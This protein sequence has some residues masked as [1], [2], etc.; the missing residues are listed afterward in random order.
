MTRRPGWH[1]E[2]ASSGPVWSL[3]ARKLGTTSGN[4]LRTSSLAI[5]IAGRRIGQPE[6]TRREIAFVTLPPCGRVRWCFG[7]VRSVKPARSAGSARGRALRVDRPF[8]VDAAL[9][10]EPPWLACE[11][12]R[13][14][15]T[16][17]VV[18]PPVQARLFAVEPAADAPLQVVVA[19]GQVTVT[20][21]D[22]AAAVIGAASVTAGAWVVSTDRWSAHITPN[23][24][25]WC[26]AGDDG[27]PVTAIRRVL[28]L[29]PPREETT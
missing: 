16:D 23:R 25:G 5:G 18:V 9:K 7:A 13:N 2:V 8:V 11:D 1:R 22:L 14:A 27:A 24:D 21:V 28:A 17:I 12:R 15:V 20:T 26:V 29:I 10:G 6:C 19:S 3:T 4:S